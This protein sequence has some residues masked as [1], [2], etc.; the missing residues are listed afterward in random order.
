MIFNI[1][2]DAEGL[3]IWDYNGHL[4]WLEL[5]GKIRIRVESVVFNPPVTD[6][7]QKAIVPGTQSNADIKLT[8]SPMVI[9]V[10]LAKYSEKI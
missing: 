5:N 4:L 9:V 10:S 3:F 6:R 1:S 8:D 7:L 2:R